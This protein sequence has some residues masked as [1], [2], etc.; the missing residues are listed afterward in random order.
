[1]QICKTNLFCH[2]LKHIL[3]IYCFFAVS[4]V[5]YRMFVFFFFC[6]PALFMNSLSSFLCALTVNWI[7]PISKSGIR[8]FTQPILLSFN[9]NIMKLLR[10]TK[11]SWVFVW[12]NQSGG[13]VVKALCLPP[14]LFLCYANTINS[15]GVTS[16]KLTH[17]FNLMVFEIV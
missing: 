17:Y 3:C 15:L 2:F 7:L 10:L 8:I 4:A 9:L 5:C 14:Y 13:S 1:M 11:I 16:A 6:T 12:N